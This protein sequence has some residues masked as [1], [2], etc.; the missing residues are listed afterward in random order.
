[1]ET[2]TQK[3]LLVG[4]SIIGGLVLGAAVG[5]AT[6]ILF[7]PRPGKDTRELIRKQ[8]DTLGDTIKDR[9]QLLVDAGKRKFGMTMQSIEEEMP[10]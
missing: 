4:C 9:G 6:G 8:A 1:M 5:A 3:A 7:A 2:T 10:S